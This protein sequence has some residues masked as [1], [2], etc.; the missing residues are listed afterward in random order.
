MRPF[1]SV[2][3]KTVIRGDNPD[4]RATVQIRY[5]DGRVRMTIRL[6]SRRGSQL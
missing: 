3:P 1:E 6:A 4:V 2:K 5:V